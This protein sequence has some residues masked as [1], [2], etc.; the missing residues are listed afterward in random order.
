MDEI[1]AV[2]V[3]SVKEL[4]EFIHQTGDPEAAF[5]RGFHHGVEAVLDALEAGRTIDEII[6]WDNDVVAP[7]R[8]SYARDGEMVPPPVL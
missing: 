6:R 3:G 2:P 7:W 8:E 4:A 5:C 1:D